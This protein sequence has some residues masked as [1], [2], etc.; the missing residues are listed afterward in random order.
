[1]QQIGVLLVR[2]RADVGSGAL[3]GDWL[4]RARRAN[5]LHAAGWGGRWCSVNARTLT[6]EVVLCVGH[7]ATKPPN[8]IRYN[9][10]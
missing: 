4:R 9:C 3:K 5:V 10:T 8:N 2:E 1:M 7:K 6:C